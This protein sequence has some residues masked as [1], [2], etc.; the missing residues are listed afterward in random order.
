MYRNRYGAEA[1]MLRADRCAGDSQAPGS[2]YGPVGGA[3]GIDNVGRRNRGGMHPTIPVDSGGY[4][5]SCGFCDSRRKYG[6]ASFITMAIWRALQALLPL[7]EWPRLSRGAACLRA[8]PPTRRR[9]CRETHTAGTI[10]SVL[11]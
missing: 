5:P 8:A 1:A 6:A 7:V 3:T 11:L 10:S 2:E 9:G 4:S